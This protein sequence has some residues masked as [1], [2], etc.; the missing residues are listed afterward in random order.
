M[1]STVPKVVSVEVVP[2]RPTETDRTM[3]AQLSADADRPIPE[4]AFIVKIRL[5]K[6]PPPTAHGWALY[7]GD[8]RIPKY[9]EYPGGIYFKVLD[10]EFL[11]DHQR[12]KLRFSENGI[13][14]IDTGVKLPG[15][16]AS[17]AKRMTG[18]SRLPLQSDVLEQS[19]PA[20][21]TRARVG[22]KSARSARARTAS[23]ASR[24]KGRKS[25]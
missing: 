13:D 15:P 7:V 14:F 1:A 5:D 20:R 10:E 3:I 2:A 19:V 17:R 25:R 16:G 12:Q 9:W 24:G 6:I 23:T 4:T 11:A 8:T 22:R 21:A 18:V